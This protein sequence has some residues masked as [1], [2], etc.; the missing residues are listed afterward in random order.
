MRRPRAVVW[1]A[2][3]VEEWQRTGVRPVVAVWTAGQTGQFLQAI[4]GHRLYAAYHLIA[5]RGLRRGEAAGLRWCDLDLDA[6]VA[7]MNQQVQQYDGH[8]VVGPPRQPAAPGPSRSIIRRW[9]RYAGTGSSRTS[10]GG[11][12]ESPTTTVDSCSLACAAVR[13]RRTGLSRTFQK[14]IAEAGLPPIRLHESAAWG[15]DPGV[16]RWRGSAGGAG[17]A[18]AL[19]D[20][21]DRQHL[22]L[23]A[24]RHRPHGRRSGR[25]AHTPPWAAR[26]RHRR[27]RRPVRQHRALPPMAPSE[28]RGVLRCSNR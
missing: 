7:T 14:L 3:R 2:A 6:R 21:A 17:H 12:E 9:P 11:A 22:H 26:T 15:G 28:H 13:L 20:R 16:I 24:A 23:R 25:R 19:L 10:N 18:R 5:L 1:T 8:I 27:P 4:R